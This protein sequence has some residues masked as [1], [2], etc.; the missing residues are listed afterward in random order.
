ML[1]GFLPPTRDSD[2]PLQQDGETL[3]PAWADETEAF[4]LHAEHFLRVA[5]AAGELVAQAKRVA[6]GLALFTE[7]WPDIKS[8]WD[9]AIEHGPQ[10]EEARRLC[11]TFFE[12]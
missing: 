12:K 2:D 9:W 5:T 10:T 7:H 4:Q 3:E 8:A 11:I 1:T 6:K